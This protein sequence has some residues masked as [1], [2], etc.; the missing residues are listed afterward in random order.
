MPPTIPPPSQAWWCGLN[1]EE[2]P[3]REEPLI[4]ES[5]NF[6]IQTVKDRVWLVDKKTGEMW[7]QKRRG[8]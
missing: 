1:S 5:K 6:L 4:V 2:E 8:K 3:K 7:E